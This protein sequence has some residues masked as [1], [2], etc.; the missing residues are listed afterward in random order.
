YD[1]YISGSGK[2]ITRSLKVIVN[3][4]HEHNITYS[5]N[6][7]IILIPGEKSN[8]SISL[9]NFGNANESVV[10]IVES[11]PWLGVWL[12]ATFNDSFEYNA[13]VYAFSNLTINATFYASKYV[14]HGIY[15]INF[16]FIDHQ[17]STTLNVPVYIAQIF[18]VEIEF[19]NDYQKITDGTA[20]FFEVIVK[21]IG[22]GL[23]NISLS[24][25]SQNASFL[26]EKDKLK[27]EANDQAI[28]KLFVKPKSRCR[29]LTIECIS[30]SLGDS[31]SD[32]AY[33]QIQPRMQKL[34]ENLC[35]FSL[36]ILILLL[37]IFLFLKYKQHRYRKGIDSDSNE[38]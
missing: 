3:V 24:A 19:K 14:K 35:C 10:I 28:V 25:I 30:T 18:D 22:N 34:E 37:V 21:N 17:F 11:T 23:D 13:K 33:I 9:S 5:V 7:P 8:Q 36:V 32:F 1:I 31:D 26:F 2:N 38:D 27:L 20:T 29:D 4:E 12:G 6:T 16:T 15:E